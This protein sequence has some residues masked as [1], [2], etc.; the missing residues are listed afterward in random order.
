MRRRSWILVVAASCLA[1]SAHADDAPPATATTADVG[2][3]I[4]VLNDVD[5]RSG[6]T[7]AK[8]IVVNDDI[9]FQEDI[10]TGEDAK[11]VIEFRDG[12]T[13]EMGPNAAVRIDSFVFNPE[14]S[15][16]HKALQVAR[17]VFRYVSGYVSSDQNTQVST[18]AGS[19][20]IRGS[21]AEGIV[22]PS[23]PD[24][25]YLGEG[26]AT[27]TNSAGSTAL[28]PGNSIAVPS[29]ATQPMA[30][31]AMPAPVAAQALQAIESRL[32]P[33]AD[34]ANRSAADDAWLKR[35]GT[36]DL[37]PVAEQQRQQAAAVNRPL[38]AGAG[39]G[40]LAGELSLLTEANRLN[41]FNGRQATRTPEQAAFLARA[42]REHPDAAM[43]LRRFDAQAR[44][45]H[46]TTM[47]RG[48]TFVLHGVGRAAPSSEVMRRVTAAA[49]RANPGAAASIQ[50]RAN[51]A[52]RGSDRGELN[53]L[54][55]PGERA[56]GPPQGGERQ[57][58]GRQGGG[59]QGGE[60]GGGPRSAGARGA[61]RSAAQRP[62]ERQLNAVG[63]RQAGGNQRAA[64]QRRPTEQRQVQPRAPQRQFAPGRQQHPAGPPQR[65][66]QQRNR[67]ERDQH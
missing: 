52:Y 62:A 8:R 31:S 36:A 16:S 41:L 27:F 34:L 63:R 51:E 30:P 56:G 14:E 26:N 54:N 37:I 28:Q 57:G 58:G 42:G 50:R 47:D 7:P 24:F 3:S 6:D 46:A 39:A 66:G 59:R 9:V 17:G 11:A 38:P 43:V 64:P 10:T 23:V 29:A 53:R 20:A 18:A 1:L 12:S 40:R 55:R 45:L 4:V 60:H 35:A 15:T 25:V 22:E 33:R 44:T 49:M 65:G 13:F 19:M 21:V 67:E 32:P 2:R 61:P 5:G 48:T